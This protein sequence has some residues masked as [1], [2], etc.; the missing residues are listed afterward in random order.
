MIDPK[1]KRVWQTTEALRSGY[2]GT[3][4]LEA[5]ILADAYV[6]AEARARMFEDGIRKPLADYVAEVKG[7]LSK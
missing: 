5:F 4:G 7:E 1:I 6:E 2:P 3:M